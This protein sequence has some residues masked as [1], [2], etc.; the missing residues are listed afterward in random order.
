MAETMKE[1]RSQWLTMTQA[2]HV[3]DIV[4]GIQASREGRHLEI[5]SEFP[6]SKPMDWAK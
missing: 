2:A 5:T 3:V 4:C 6:P 1:N